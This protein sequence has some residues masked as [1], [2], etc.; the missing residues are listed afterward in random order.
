MS[1]PIDMNTSMQTQIRTENVPNANG[2]LTLGIL[3]LVFMG[4]VGIIL[5]TIALSISAGPK[6]LYELDPDKYTVSSY[7]NL[8]AGRVCAIISLSI[9]GTLILILLL[10]LASS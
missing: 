2:V 9:S 8:K 5:A 7:K 1:E 4:L 10:A 6:G 3:S